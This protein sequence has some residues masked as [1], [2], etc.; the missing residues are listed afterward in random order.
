MLYQLK[1]IYDYIVSKEVWVSQ[2]IIDS[3]RNLLT[4]TNYTMYIVH[5]T[6]YIPSNFYI[7]NI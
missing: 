1:C 6:F 7:M 2:L 3:N 4:E 5:I